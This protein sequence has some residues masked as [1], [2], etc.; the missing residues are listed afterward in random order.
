M[1]PRSPMPALASAVGQRIGKPQS[2]LSEV[3]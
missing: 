2:G 3:S 1:K